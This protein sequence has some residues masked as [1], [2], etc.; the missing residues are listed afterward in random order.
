MSTPLNKDVTRESTIKVDDREINITITSNQEIKMKLKGMKSGEVS[1]PIQDLYYQLIGKTDVIVNDKPKKG[2]TSVIRDVE[3][4]TKKNPMISLFDLRSQ[5]AIS[6]L[7]IPT[8][9]KFDQIIKNLID[10]IKS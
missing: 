3:K 10:T 4:S 2:S 1:I 5:N 7:D 6:T 8:L 9:A